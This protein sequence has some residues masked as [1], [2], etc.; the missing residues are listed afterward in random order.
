MNIHYKKLALAG[1]LFGMSM[2]A[3]ADL[4]C[5]DESGGSSRDSMPANCGKPSKPVA[6]MPVPTSST[7]STS[8]APDA[9]G[10]PPQT[11]VQPQVRRPNNRWEL[12]AADMSIY[13]AMKRW[14]DL[15]GW[16]ISWEIPV[17]FPVTIVGVFD[18]NFRGA[19]DTV[20]DAYRGADFPPKGCFYEN[21]VLRVVRRIGDG[22]ECL[23]KAQ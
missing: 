9:R 11:A 10:I 15:A 22:K 14:T 3:R 16:Q 6:L 13:G 8:V 2:V 23:V 4:V 18:N 1:L 19:I 5:M 20:L 12:R 21:N 7:N 17:D